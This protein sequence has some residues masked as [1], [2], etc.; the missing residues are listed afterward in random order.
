VIEGKELGER[1]LKLVTEHPEQHDNGT[2]VNGVD[3]HRDADVC[4]TTACLAGW[5]VVLNARK[6]ESPL[7]AMCRIARETGVSADWEE[8]G[9][10][11]LSG[12]PID[13]DREYEVS[14]YDDQQD[15]IKDAFYTSGDNELA[16]E[17][18]A[19]ALGID[20]DTDA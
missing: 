19:R 14:R 2:W 16:V 12:R 18:L 15:S 1:V 5:A 13:W 9:V 17:L 7:D 6:G 4:D 8:V 20:L 11:L 10:R 3:R